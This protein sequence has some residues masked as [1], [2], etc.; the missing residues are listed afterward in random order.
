MTETTLMRQVYDQLLSQET[1]AQSDDERFYIS[2]LLGH[3]SLV[4]SQAE[5]SDADFAEAMDSSLEAAFS[6]D[7]LSANDK[8]A[9]RALWQGLTASK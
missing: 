4:G 6:S 9:I 1:A 5:Y 8:N 2:Y 3:V 7:Q